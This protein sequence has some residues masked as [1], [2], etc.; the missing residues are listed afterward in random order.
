MPGVWIAGRPDALAAPMRA[1]K[2]I[3]PDSD[4]S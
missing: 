3:T 2:E 1:I 4:R